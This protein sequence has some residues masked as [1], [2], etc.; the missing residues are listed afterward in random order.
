VQDNGPGISEEELTHIFDRFYRGE[1][2]RAINAPGTGIGLPVAQKIIE[3]YDGFVDVVSHLGKGS[4]FSL[5]FPQ[6]I[7]P[8]A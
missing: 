1:I 6:A 8:T 2:A 5:W 3:Q 4:T 7:N